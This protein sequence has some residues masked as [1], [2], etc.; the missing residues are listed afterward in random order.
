MKTSKEVHQNIYEAF[1]WETGLEISLWG[2]SGFFS[3]F[4]HEACI[5]VRLSYVVATN[6]RESKGLNTKTLCLLSGH[7]CR[8]NTQQ[9]SASRRSCYV[10][11]QTGKLARGHFI[12]RSQTYS[13]AQ[14]H[15]FTADGTRSN[16]RHQHKSP[17]QHLFLV[18]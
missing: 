12:S 3:C 6:S 14:V 17:P 2:V 9:V 18:Q 13:S 7:P 16:H 4:L 5:L 10:I 1:C 11:P 15:G 8:E